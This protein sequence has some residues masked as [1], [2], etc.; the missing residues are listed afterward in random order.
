[1]CTSW[2]IRVKTTTNRIHAWQFKCMLTLCLIYCS[3]Y[4]QQFNLWLFHWHSFLLVDQTSIMSH[5][6]YCSPSEFTSIFTT[7]IIWWLYM[8]LIIHNVGMLHGQPEAINNSHMWANRGIHLVSF[9][10]F[11]Y[12]SCHFYM[13]NIN[14]LFPVHCPCLFCTTTSGFTIWNT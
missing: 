7:P 10:N 13:G 6:I 11:N 3:M 1:M 4:K 14:T 5:K 9:Y 12:L 8:S 2:S